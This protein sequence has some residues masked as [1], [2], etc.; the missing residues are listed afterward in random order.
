MKA[1]IDFPEAPSLMGWCEKSVRNGMALETRFSVSHSHCGS[2][3]L[4]NLKA[5]YLGATVHL[6][7]C[8]LAVPTAIAMRF[9]NS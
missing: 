7:T 5:D 1:S 8:L 6:S 3:P 2:A 9:Y 4:T